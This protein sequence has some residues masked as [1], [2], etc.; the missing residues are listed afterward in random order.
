MKGPFDRHALDSM[1][2]DRLLLVPDLTLTVRSPGPRPIA[3]IMR[4]TRYGRLA[5]F[6]SWEQRALSSWTEADIPAA[7][8]RATW[9][10]HEQGWQLVIERRGDDV[11]VFEGGDD[12]TTLDMGFR[13]PLGRWIEAW[14]EVIGRAAHPRRIT[15]R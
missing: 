12:W 8:A 5:S 9:D 15:L 4:S 14:R 7:G 1:A 10:G 13:V 3:L 6:S 11:L 2:A